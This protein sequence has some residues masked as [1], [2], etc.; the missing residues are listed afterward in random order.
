MPDRYPIGSAF[1]VEPWLTADLQELRPKRERAAETGLY[2]VQRFQSWR[3]Y[4]VRVGRWYRS[5]Y[6][7][8]DVA[9]NDA[10]GG[11]LWVAKA[12]VGGGH[13]KALP[14]VLQL[15]D[16]ATGQ[17]IAEHTVMWD[18][19]VVGAKSFPGP[20][21][22]SMAML[23][24]PRVCGL[25]AVF[26]EQGPPTVAWGRNRHTKS[27]GIWKPEDIEKQAAKLAGKP[28]K[29]FSDKDDGPWVVDQPEPPP[30]G[31]TRWGRY[32]AGG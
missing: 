19:P 3:V 16:P 14:N 26:G 4:P 17:P 28:Y 25:F 20:E 11:A 27:G 24:D 18:S 31:K 7:D 13:W 1:P 15:L 23:G 22:R 8:D 12:V 30:G 2:L 10:V 32:K 6:V 21:T 9:L 5:S 29:D